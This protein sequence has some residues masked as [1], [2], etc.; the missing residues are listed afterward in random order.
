MLEKT[1][2][3]L[4]Q[5]VEEGVIPGAAAAVGVGDTV[6]ARGFFGHRQVHGEELPVTPNTLWDLASLSKVTAT[7]MTAL[8]LLQC[9]VIGPDDPLEK[10]FSAADCPDAALWQVRR[11]VTLRQLLTHT[12]GF[13]PGIPLWEC[14]ESPADAAKAILLS[15]PVCAPGEQVYYSCLG[16]ILLQRALE[17]V[18]GVPLDVLAK[19]EVFDPLGMRDTVYCPLEKGCTDIAATEWPNPHGR[20]ICGTVHD[21]NAAFLGG[22]SG[23]AGVFST[24][25]DMERFAAMLGQK[26]LVPMEDGNTFLL[27]EIAAAMLTDYTPGLAESRGLVL[28]LRGAAGVF[29]G[30]EGLSVGSWG[31]T[32]FTGTSLYVDAATGVW[33]VV[34]TNAVHYGRERSRW[35][36]LRRA[37][38]AAAVQEY[39]EQ[40]A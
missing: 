6:L 11:R 12:G 1:F 25:A 3:L 28:Q 40:R 34:L 38:Y 14:C 36:A 29:H 8:R 22:V 19:R 33:G 15:K 9:G 17:K 16:F 37:F 35:F 7:G 32:G 21:E 23:N 31:H 10:Y 26:G 4:R 27:P 5:G 18:T 20:Y 24:L 2:S 13:A 39:T 30:G